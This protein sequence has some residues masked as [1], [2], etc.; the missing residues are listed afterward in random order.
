MNAKETLQYWWDNLG[1]EEQVKY[2]LSEEINNAD[3]LEEINLL[4][5]IWILI[6]GNIV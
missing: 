2:Q 4:N 6:Y 5:E 3:T 1:C